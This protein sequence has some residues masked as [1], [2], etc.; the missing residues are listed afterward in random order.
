MKGLDGKEGKCRKNMNVG[1]LRHSE[2]LFYLWAGI[3]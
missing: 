1:R 2:R 3:V